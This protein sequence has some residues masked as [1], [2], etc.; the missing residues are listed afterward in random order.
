[1]AVRRARPRVLIPTVVTV[2][3]ASLVAVGTPA[4]AVEMCLG[5]L[6][7]IVGSGTITGTPGPDVIVGSLGVDTIN[8][9]GGDDVICGL[10]GNDLIDSGAGSDQVSDG[11]GADIVDLG[12]DDDV[13]TSHT[14]KDSHDLIDGSGG[15]DQIRYLRTNA[16][17]VNLS[18]TASDDGE[19]GEADKL[20]NVDSVVGGS[21][22]DK[23]V[24]GFGAD[25][26]DGGA[27]NDTFNGQSGADV[28][29]GG[30]GNDIF[31]EAS[32]G[33][34]NDSING[35]L[36]IDEVSYA[37]R[38]EGVDIYLDGSGVSGEFG[39]NDVITNAENARGGDGNDDIFGT[40]GP[41][42][43]YGGEGADAILD[44]L[45]ADKVDTGTGCDYMVQPPVADPGDVLNGGG[46]ACDWIDYFDRTVG[47]TISLKTTAAVNGAPGEGDKVTGAEN[48]YAGSGDDTITGTGAANQLNANTGGADVIKGLGGADVLSVDDDMADDE[49]DGGFGSDTGYVDPGDYASSVETIH[50]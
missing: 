17:K 38:F 13:L 27:G 30:A 16:L 18:T 47:V 23:L 19:I 35:G 32:G 37:G 10:A 50:F 3:A 1:M 34:E 21:G 48:V 29:L 41:N 8:G 7:T 44:G 24:G 49:I 40:S 46:G 2:A 11:A 15:W 42:V 25:L 9:G 31:L 39:E 12:A 20:V 5:N 43:L 45:G 4:H 28:L 26:L 6:S 22:N 36:D 33:N 14:S